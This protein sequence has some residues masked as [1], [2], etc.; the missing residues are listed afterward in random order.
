MDL[1]RRLQ[2]EPVVAAVE[3]DDE[4]EAVTGTTAADEAVEETASDEEEEATVVL[5]LVCPG[6]TQFDPVNPAGVVGLVDA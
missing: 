6:G 2:V 1:F 4:D 5:P 3:A